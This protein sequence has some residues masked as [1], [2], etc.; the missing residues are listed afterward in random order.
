[1]N[2]F[3]N[4]L[5][6]S[7]FLAWLAANFLYITGFTLVT[8]GWVI[9][10]ALAGL[11]ILSTEVWYLLQKRRSLFYLFL[12]LLS[13]VGFIILLTLT[14]KRK[15]EKADGLKVWQVGELSKLV[16][17]DYDLR[18]FREVLSCPTCIFDNQEAAKQGQPWCDAS[19]PPDIEKNY[20]HTFTAK[21]KV[22]K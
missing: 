3:K 20:C 5:N 4:H 13:W 18:Y 12:N 14:N 11:L 9:L 10:F 21:L 17:T 16:H 7:F 22:E 1:M 19:N 6:W 15:I 2:W 8:Q